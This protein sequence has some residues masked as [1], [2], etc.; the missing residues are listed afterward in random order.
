MRKIK[1]S[2]SPLDGEI[3]IVD[4]SDG[5]IRPKIGRYDISKSRLL[6]YA[7]LP[8]LDEKLYNTV[9]KKI[10]NIYDEINDKATKDVATQSTNGLMSYVDKKKIDNLDSTVATAVGAAVADIVIDDGTW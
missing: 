1:N 5:Y 10:G 7:E 4:A 8:F 3:I 6:T 2:F 9:G